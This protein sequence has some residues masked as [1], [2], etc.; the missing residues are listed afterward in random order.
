MKYASFVM[1]LLLSFAI[2][3]PLSANDL[4]ENPDVTLRVEKS[5]EKAVDIL[6]LN[7]Q[8]KRTSITLTTLKG[9]DTFFREVVNNH[10]GYRK[11]FDL[12]NL[13]PGKY[14]LT[15]EQGDKKIRQVIVIDA[16]RGM[17]LSNIVG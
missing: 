8:Q 3:L 13:L 4:P 7:L 17:M 9:S 6:L 2:T 11:R 1:T 5:K 12:S 10:N 16:E 14:I 15:V